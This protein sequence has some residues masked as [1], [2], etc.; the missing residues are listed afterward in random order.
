[1]KGRIFIAVSII[2]ALLIAA[3]PVN[4]QA[5]PGQI[6]S[7]NSPISS[8]LRATLDTWLQDP[9][10]EAV[11]YA[12][13]YTQST[14]NGTYV[15]IAGLD[16]DS[17]EE[18]WSLT[19]TTSTDTEGNVSV[20]N[21]VL[22]MDTI[23][24]GEDGSISYPFQRPQASA[25]FKNAMPI[26]APL[27]GAGGG[28]YVMFPWQPA[29]AVQYG[30]AGLHMAE[31]GWNVGYAVDL[32]SGSEMGSGA[33]S[34][35]VYASAGGTV[36]YMCDFGGAIAFRITG[37]DDFLYANLLSNENLQIG[38]TFSPGE[39][40]GTLRHG[41]FVDPCASVVQTNSQWELHWGFILSSDYK[42]Q[43]EGCILKGNFNPLTGAFISPLATWTCGNTKVKP[44]GFLYHYGNISASPEN[45]TIGTHVLVG[46]GGGPSFWEYL[47]EGATNIL[48]IL[49]LDKLPAHDSSMNTFINAIMNGVK[50]VFRIVN[51]LIRG[52]LN[53]APAATVIL[54]AIG[55]KMALGTLT[56]AGY[57]LRIIKSIPGA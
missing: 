14:G 12:V 28:A 23:L 27:Y 11:Y 3:M 33:A 4:A 44:L 31:L 42:F 6:V 40:L 22:W 48:N 2:A 38:E 49:I 29:K 45:G 8:E 21:K 26:E 24:V 16:L 41:S 35:A 39:K 36:S 13:T 56:L 30:I 18:E 46:N 5:E 9:P 50:I 55:V 1:M 15:S 10:S 43:A 7:I 52:N 20:E 37:A 57:I 51:V 34:D 47:L 54:I 32:K 25:I 53:L 17:P 19:G